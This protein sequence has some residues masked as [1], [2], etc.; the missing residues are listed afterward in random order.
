MALIKRDS[1]PTNPETLIMIKL[2]EKMSDTKAKLKYFDRL[3][4]LLRLRLTEIRRDG[5][6]RG[7]LL[8]SE[9]TEASK[10][11]LK[12]LMEAFKEIDVEE[13]TNS[14][15]PKL[16]TIQRNRMA[17]NFLEMMDQ[18]EKFEYFKRFID[19]EKFDALAQK[20]LTGKA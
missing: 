11:A 15:K 8:D 16:T 9:I 13:S 2:F 17:V 19:E 1:K 18:P 4:M 5:A 14:K 7:A 12:V 20:V 6:K 3:R 10:P